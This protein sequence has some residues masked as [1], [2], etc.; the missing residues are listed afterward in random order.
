MIVGRKVIVCDKC[1]GKQ[2]THSSN[3]TRCHVCLPKCREKHHF[4]EL[5]TGGNL[6][7]GKHI[8]HFSTRIPKSHHLNAF[9]KLQRKKLKSA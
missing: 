9:W 5:V 4:G 6:K 8:A 2:S 3:R 1:G 7:D